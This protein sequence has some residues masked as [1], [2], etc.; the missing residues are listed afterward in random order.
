LGDQFDLKS[1]LPYI[2]QQVEANKQN[3]IEDMR[4]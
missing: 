1:Q 3:I 2:I 4:L